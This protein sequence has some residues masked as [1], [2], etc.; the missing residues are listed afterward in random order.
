MREFSMLSGYTENP[1]KPQSCR[2]WGGGGGGGGGGAA[3]TGMGACSGQYGNCLIEF[4]GL[5]SD[6]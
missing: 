5:S 3:C 1:E 6:V 2:N 4:T